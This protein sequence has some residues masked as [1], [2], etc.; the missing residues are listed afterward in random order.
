VISG[1][2]RIHKEGKLKMAKYEHLLIYKKAM[3]PRPCI[4]HSRLTGLRLVE[5]RSSF[6]SSW[7]VQDLSSR[8]RT[9][10]GK[11]GTRVRRIPDKLE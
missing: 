9:D 10:P 2:L 4:R 7:L 11:A 6:L 5:N 1:F 8:F 3:D